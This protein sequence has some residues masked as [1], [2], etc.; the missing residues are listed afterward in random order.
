MLRLY[1]RHFNERYQTYGRFVHF[2]A[3]YDR[4]GAATPE[5]RRSDAADN[6]QRIKP[7]AVFNQGSFGFGEE[8]TDVMARHGV[9]VFTG[10]QTERNLCCVAAA[11]FQRYP[12][13]LWSVAASTEQ[14][15]RTFASLVCRRVV[16]RPV[17]YGG[18]A[19]DRARPRVLGLLVNRRPG[20]EEETHLATLV[21]AQVEACGGSFKAEGVNQ[22]QPCSFQGRAQEEMAKFQ[23]ANVT[24]IIWPA[25]PDAG[26]SDCFGAELTHA[27]AGLGYLPEVVVAGSGGSE[28]GFSATYDN[29]AFWENVIFAS[30]YTRA[31]VFAERPCAQAAREADNDAPRQDIETFG[32][33]LYDGV[34]LMFTGIQV[35]GPRL[36]PTSVDKGFHA[37]PS[38]ASTDPR[39]PA[40]FFAP[41]DYTCVKDALLG[42]W[43]PAG[44]EPGSSNNGCMRMIEGGRR[45]LAGGWPRRDIAADKR[46]NDPCNRQGFAL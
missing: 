33:M 25:G 40:C 1:Q 32:C 2:Y 37:I 19:G 15:A 10:N 24:T 7:F 18:N 14:Y 30:P 29:Q 31:D 5:T 43:D 36:G 20:Q 6:F 13:L 34:R 9:L 45:Y 17:S 41:G 11:A 27:S 26:G 28:T 16:G 39:V 21:K 8:Y 22:G 23:Q 38:V 3:Y 4:E 46:S 42:W 35:A 44:R 12:K